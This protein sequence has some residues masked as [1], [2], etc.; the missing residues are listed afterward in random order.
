MV[1]V[2]PVVESAQCSVDSSEL[3]AKSVAT[4]GNITRLSFNNIATDSGEFLDQRKDSGT[5]V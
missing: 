3:G 4:T 1:K 2:Y 5:F